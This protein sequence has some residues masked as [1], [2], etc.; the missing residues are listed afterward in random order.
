VAKVAI[1]GTA[2]IRD[3]GALADLETEVREAKIVEVYGELADMP[4]EELR[5]RSIGMVA[6]ECDLSDEKLRTLS[7]SRIRVWLALDPETV[8][9]VS[10]PYEAASEMMSS[11]QA[12]R[13][14]GLLQALRGSFSQEDRK[15]LVAAAP[16]VFGGAEERELGSFS[17]ERPDPRTSSK[18]RA[19]GWWPFGR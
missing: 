3:W 18:N 10:P 13:R 12:I 15:R 2:A 11:S 7:I 6:A 9:K 5:S 16:K 4:E 8:R 1:A 14:V 17:R 19:R